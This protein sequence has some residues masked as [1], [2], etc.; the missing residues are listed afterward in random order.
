VLTPI[1][2]TFLS[3]SAT[4]F[5]KADLVERMISAHPTPYSS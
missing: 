2:N 1:P 3:T 4:H 5:R